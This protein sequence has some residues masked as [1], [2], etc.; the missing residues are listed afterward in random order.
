MLHSIFFLFLPFAKE[1][2]KKRQHLKKERS[3]HVLI[4]HRLMKDIQDLLEKDSFFFFFFF[5]MKKKLPQ[6]NCFINISVK[7]VLKL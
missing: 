5:L 3:L 6:N 1:N 4:K 2:R 7:K